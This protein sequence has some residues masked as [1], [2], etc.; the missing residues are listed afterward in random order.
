MPPVNQP[1]TWTIHDVYRKRWLGVGTLLPFLFLISMSLPLPLAR[2][3]EAVRGPTTVP[4]TA[5]T[6]LGLGSSGRCRQHL[7]SRDLALSHD[8]SYPATTWGF[9]GAVKVSLR[10]PLAQPP[11]DRSFSFSA[12]PA[13]PARWS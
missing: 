10:C 2:C 7:L 3:A 5:L 6:R 4:V 11:A 13:V 8:V 12:G 9:Y 1:P